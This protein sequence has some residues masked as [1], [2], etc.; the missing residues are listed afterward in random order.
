MPRWL[1]HRGAVVLLLGLTALFYW[2]LIFSDRFT[3]LDSPDLMGQV[4]P[5]YNV[6]AQ[7]WNEGEFPMW[8]PYVWGGQSLLGQ[9]QPGGA[10]P[11]NWPLFL[12][13]LDDDGRID[14]RW[15][16]LHFGLIRLLPALFFYL[17][18][19]ELGCRRFAALLAGLAFGCG[20]YIS[21]IGWPQMLHG[22]I[23]F[24]LTLYFLARFVRLG[25]T[26][27]GA[28]N[29]VLCGGSIGFSLLS[30]HHQ[31][32]FFSLLAVTGVFAYLWWRRFQQSRVEAFRLAALYGASAATAFLVAALQLLPALEYGKLAYRWVNAAEPVG[33]EDPVP[34][35]VHEQSRLFPITL[36]GAVV[37]RAYFQT[38]TQV[39]WVCLALALLAV[40]TRWN[41]TKTRIAAGLAVGGLAI[42]FGPFSLLHGWLYEF[43][44]MA[45]K[46]RTGAHAVFVFQA[47]VFLLAA[48]GVER[49]LDRGWGEA[50]EKWFEWAGK[51]LLSFAALTWIILYFQVGEGKM[52]AAPGDHMMIAAL[53]ALSLAAVLLAW[54]RSAIGWG[55]L[56]FALVALTLTE[57]YAPQWHFLSD[58]G[59]PERRQ[60]L[61]EYEPYRG[62]MSFVEH[63]QNSRWEPL[64][65]EIA[66]PE[67]AGHNVGA[68]YGVQQMDGFLASANRD[69]Y[70]LMGRDGWVE[71]RL[72]MG[73][74][75]TLAKEPTRPDQIKVYEDPQWKVFENPGA[76]PRAWLQHSG[77]EITGPK[78]ETEGLPT[79]ESCPDIE[80]RPVGFARWTLRRT[81]LNVAPACSAWL[82]LSDPWY[83]GW[84]AEV[85]GKLTTVYRYKKALRAVPVPAGE[86]VVQIIYR[87]R[88]VFLGGWL[89]G[90]GLLLCAGATFVALRRRS[91]AS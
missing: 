43:V 13:P 37:P 45:E 63:A 61:A 24:P 76:N 38:N 52:E 14:L 5:W 78:G 72:L 88:S 8:D 16:S 20:G 53:V 65:F 2:K 19:R 1:R 40:A 30:G 73:T 57:L 35:F 50:G 32:P 15:M 60:Y 6:Q 83:P 22:A 44:P 89:T 36:F 3:F 55:G 91:A 31:T 90:F 80:E 67:G 21:T 74:R 11:L 48:L 77:A 85:D 84:E 59:D 39:G 69:L 7:A 58:I 33:Y 62:A 54:R 23:W 9:M 68:W 70:D 26:A 28:A 79:V 75:Y 47:G 25:W 42:G 71:T 87:P 29:A 18:V 27:A 86:Y 82:I 64:R 34:Y 46:A 51:I 41:E 10:F 56:R 49:L 12:A 81:L 4:A 17:L 66:G